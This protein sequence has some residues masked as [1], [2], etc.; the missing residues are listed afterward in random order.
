M[1]SKPTK[2]F[3]RTL[4][5][6]LVM[7]FVF[8][9]TLFMGR[10]FAVGE[11]T[12]PPDNLLQVQQNAST[13]TDNMDGVEQ[14]DKRNSFT[15]VYKLENGEYAAIVSGLPVHYIEDGVYK[16]IDNS[17]S[18]ITDKSGKQV[19]VN[20]D[21][22]FKAEISSLS[23]GF[24]MSRGIYKISWTVDGM[25]KDKSGLKEEALTKEQWNTMSKG[26]KRKN[27]PNISSSVTYKGVMSDVD[28]QYAVISNKL[29][30]NIILN[31][32]TDITQVVER[33]KTENLDL[34]KN[35]DNSISAV[36]IKTKE[37]VFILPAPF[38][39]DNEGNIC[40]NVGVDLSLKEKEYILTYTLDT[41]W[42]ETAVYPCAIDPSVTINGDT[43]NLIDNK[44]LS[45]TAYRNTCYSN[46]YFVSTGVGSSSGTNQ[47]LIKFVSLPYDS[48]CTVD[49]AVLRLQMTYNLATTS[50][51]IRTH[52]VNYNWTDSVTWTSFYANSTPYN[53]A[54]Y[55]QVTVGPTQYQSY[56][57]DIKDIA[58]SWKATNYGV[59]LDDY[60]TT[61]KYKIYASTNLDGVHP[62]TPPIGYF[63]WHDSTPP[64]APTEFQLWPMPWTN[65]NPTIVWSGITDNGGSGLAKAQYSID[66]APYNDIPTSNGISSGS[67]TIDMSGYPTGEYGINIRAVDGYG[68]PGVPYPY[69]STYYRDISAPHTPNQPTIN[70]SNDPNNSNNVVI[71][72]S[73]STV[74]DPPTEVAVTRYG[75][76]MSTD[77]LNYT[78]IDEKTTPSFQTSQPDNTE[79]YFEI[80]ACDDAGLY[81]E[82]NYVD[83]PHTS[84]ITYDRTGPVIP[85][86][87]VSISPDTS[88]QNAWTKVVT[89]TITWQNITD[90]GS[91]L[92]YIGMQIDGT[93]DQN[94]T[95]IG[96]SAN[97]SSII[98]CGSLPDGT[99]TVYVL[100]KDS[101]GN[102]SNIIS[103]T[104]KKD[105]TIN[106]DN[107]KIETPQMEDVVTVEPS[108]DVIIYAKANDEHLASWIIDYAFGTSPQ[109]SDFIDHNISNG[110]STLIN[111]PQN[112]WHVSSLNLEQDRI[113]TIKL[114]A[115]DAAGN[116]ASHSIKV[117]Y[118]VDVNGVEPA[119]A[120]T[121]KDD[122]NNVIVESDVIDVDNVNA[123]Y[124][125]STGRMGTLYV[126]DE[127]KD[128]ESTGNMDLDFNPLQYDSENNQW[129]YPEGSQVF[130]RTMTVDENDKYD[131]T[132]YS[133]EGHN[134]T[135]SFDSDSGIV[136]DPTTTTRI[137]GHIELK[138]SILEG[139]FTSTEQKINGRIS[140]VDLTVD[141]EKPAGSTIE[142]RLIYGSEPNN[143]IVL[144][145]G[146]TILD[147]P[148]NSYT[149]KATMSRPNTSVSPKVNAWHVKTM[150]VAF[151]DSVVV[152]NS[153]EDNGR[154][155]CCLDKVIHNEAHGWIELAPVAA[156]GIGYKTSG[157]VLS[158][159]RVTPGKVWE[160]HLKV[161][162]T[163][164]TGSIS[165]SISTDGGTYWQSIIPGTNPDIDTWTPI[166][167]TGN[168]IV[169]KAE[170]SGDGS[171]TPQLERWILKCRQTMAG[172]AHDVKF[173]DEPDNLSTLVDAN[174]MTLLRWEPSETIGVTY[175][176][177]RST[178]PYFDITT[179]TP[180]KPGVTTNY[181]S[182]F[183]LN[184][185]QRFYY[186]VTAV[187][188][189]EVSPGVFANRESL[190][191]NEAWADVVAQNELEKK[192]GLENY[193]TYDGYKAGNG[194]GYVNIA[195]GNTVFQSTDT[196]IPGPFFGMVMRRTYN[197][198]ADT[199]TPMGYGWDYSFNTCLFKELDA[200][201]V[202]LA[203]ILKDGD[204]SFHRFALEEGVYKAAKG[205]F[206]SL[207]LEN[208][209][210][211]VKRKDDV[212]YHFS[213]Q[214]MK[215][216]KF[217]NLNNVELSFFYDDRGNLSM[218][219]ND[220][221]ESLT[222]EYFVDGAVETD[223]DY[224]YVNN[225]VDMLKHVTWTQD[226][227]TNPVS[228]VYN[229]VYDDQDRLTEVHTTYKDHLG[230]HNVCMSSFD[231]NA[232]LD[233]DATTE[234][235]NV[236][237]TDA[238]NNKTVILYNVSG[239]VE[240][241][242]DPVTT[243]STLSSAH[244]KTYT[245]EDLTGDDKTTV[246]TDLGIS[247]IY[248]YD[249]N[250]VNQDSGMLTRFEDALGH[251]MAYNNDYVNMLVLSKMYQN[252]VGGVEKNIKYLYVYD[253]NGNIEQVKAQ[254]K[255]VSAQDYTD[256][257]PQTDYTYNTTFPNMIAT[258]SVKKD[259][260]TTVVTSYEYYADGKLHTVTV[261]S[262]TSDAK[263]TTYDYYS[264]SGSEGLQHQL[265]STTDEF[266]KKTLYIYNTKGQLVNTDEYIAQDIQ[267]IYVRT[268]GTY[269]YDAYGYT[270][271]LT[272][273]Y[274]K[275]AS[276]PTPHVTNLDYD[277]LGRLE[278]QVNPDNTAIKWEYDLNGNNTFIKYGRMNGAEFEQ[279]N[280]VVNVYDCLDR[281]E[282]STI[283]NGSGTADDVGS[284]INYNQKW[285]ST[286]AI[287]GS[288]SS[289][290]VKTDPNTLLQ[291]HEY[292]NI[293]GQLVKVQ[294]YDGSSY[295]T[296]AEYEYDAAG[297][298]I[299]S[300]DGAGRVSKAYYNELNQQVSTVT[301]PFVTGQTGHLNLET[302]YTY[303]YLG[304]KR[305]VT[306][307]SYSEVAGSGSQET[308]VDSY[309]SANATDA[310][311]IVPTTSLGQSFDSGSV[312]RQLSKA[313]FYIYRG[314]DANGSPNVYARLYAH[315]GTWGSTGIPATGLNSYLAQSDP[316]S[317]NSLSETAG[318]VEFTFST[319]YTLA[320]NTKYCLML[321]L[322]NDAS[323]EIVAMEDDSVYTHP[324]NA[325][326]D[327]EGDG[328]WEEQDWCD[329]IFEVYGIESTGTTQT[330]T[331][332]TTAYTYD[333]LS[334]LKTVSQQ[335]PN[336]NQTEK[337]QSDLEYLVTRYE[338]D[339]EG[340]GDYEGLICNST[341]DPLN[342]LQDT[343]FDEMGRKKYDINYGDV[344][345]N[346]GVPD[347]TNDPVKKTTIYDE[348]DANF[349]LIWITRIDGSREN[350]E[351]NAMGQVTHAYYYENGA[352]TYTAN[353]DYAYYD[354][355]GKLHSETITDGTGTHTTSYDYDAMGRVT[356]VWDGDEGSGGLDLEYEYELDGQLKLLNYMTT[357]AYDH[358]LVYVY[359]NFRRISEIRLDPVS[360][361]NNVVRK[362]NYNTTTG[363]IQNVETAR[364]FTAFNNGNEDDLKK[365]ITTAYEF[366][367]AGKTS[368]ITV[369]DA[370]FIDTNNSTGVTE[371]YTVKY[372]GRGYINQETLETDYSTSTGI[373][374]KYKGYLYDEIGR[375]AKAG[376]GNDVPA[377]WDQWA[378][379]SEYVYDGV[380]NRKVMTVGSETT[381]YDYSDYNQLTTVK[382]GSDV[383]LESY[384]FDARGNQVSV[385]KYDINGMLTMH[386]DYVFDLL[387]RMT[388]TTVDDSSLAYDVITKNFY[389]A[390][391]QRI[392]KEIWN[393]TQPNPAVKT[394]T[395]KYFYT[396]SSVL[397]TTDINSQIKTENVL[398][399]SG[400][401]I[402]SWRNRELGSQQA[403]FYNYDIRGSVTNIVTSAGMTENGYSYD[404]F[405]NTQESGNTNFLNETT[406]TGSIK[407]D[408][409]GL[410]YM[411]ARFYDAKSGRFLSQDSYSGNAYDPWTQHLYSYCGNNPTNFVDP[412]GHI[413]VIADDENGRPIVSQRQLDAYNARIA[414]KNSKPAPTPI[415]ITLYVNSFMDGTKIED[416]QKDA[417]KAAELLN[418]VENP[419]Y[420][421]SIN[422]KQG[423]LPNNLVQI[424]QSG[425][426]NIPIANGVWK[427]GPKNMNQMPE[428]S[429]ANP[430][431]RIFQYVRGD[432]MHINAV[433]LIEEMTHAVGM[434]EEHY[435]NEGQGYE[436]CNRNPCNFAG[437][438]FAD[439]PK[440]DT[441]VISR[442]INKTLGDAIMNYPNGYVPCP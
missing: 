260:G 231:Y 297:N 22:A 200:N 186:K 394:D 427:A 233:N 30:E 67:Y 305:S 276:P 314:S 257:G 29:I 173:I 83:S 275:N 337:P 290:I 93:N 249:D 192:L 407:D 109:E 378:N 33:L 81:I 129:I 429:L 325:I 60:Y 46:T 218:V 308:L 252:T 372:D 146:K 111:T 8:T 43:S 328:S 35:E 123:Y 10:A 354:T 371:R 12:P 217:T 364:N 136:L 288:E 213:A 151:S 312:S 40:N 282:S 50:S 271:T 235:H 95:Q 55:S 100:A 392:M 61:N 433:V 1:T 423:T 171:H 44:I 376:N 160:A 25:L 16:D 75:L 76:L 189:I 391:G 363:D 98:Q 150:Y 239:A 176:V 104:Y 258:Q 253:D 383:T 114:T 415:V 91:N 284:I 287:S 117:M 270:D 205:T 99:H 399:Q 338:Y 368:K 379:K 149:L 14:I 370:D 373:T 53:T 263:T 410:Q 82:D 357:G 66:G 417:D 362:Y 126:N 156:P 152:N 293:I 385:N 226:V 334:R 404:E 359:D 349:N 302:R 279:R 327:Y 360:G 162:Q 110:T 163:L 87:S 285:D 28:L 420:T 406:Y 339:V 401:I 355:N 94:W 135:D 326:A 118:A 115:T 262:G 175:N 88:S 180:I 430:G 438:A 155:F 20:K 19:Y 439:F 219:T 405:G 58:D 69:W 309:G 316:V 352:Q 191:S 63:T 27:V 409:T 220:V 259:S 382:N 442:T 167:P 130:I 403:Y 216:E 387:N 300:T 101:V 143:F 121:L 436:F 168:Q 342:R 274:N 254:S 397:Y 89:P 402:A 424:E 242:Y 106:P 13:I 347:R 102:S 132:N 166:T 301:D 17:M 214:T 340:E 228:T 137:D 434:D 47:T 298:Q 251:Y 97:G 188:S 62:G 303:D 11:T 432:D 141:E 182:D 247:S 174:Y 23:D 329:L 428:Q 119:L 348:Y 39:T 240:K 241:I 7:T 45:A 286:S 172:E 367:G 169:L 232:N 343:Y 154:G 193:W 229:Y 86:G 18:L 183:N 310:E 90:E 346:A 103:L 267:D 283:Q 400:S 230:N 234:D 419:E 107:V 311:W 245:Y 227:E 299:K 199:K 319:P 356:S 425:Q 225:N 264:T 59:L 437:T 388:S 315:S 202:E 41:K 85:A 224:I 147:L 341:I 15:K 31:K 295:L 317:V 77:N 145:P 80:R 426:V 197:L 21:N 96:S 248:Y 144:T 78:K 396:G 422:V 203:I 3:F 278:K 273:A 185:G 161:D 386:G 374:T 369:S 381:K 42:L 256:L 153:F 331:D 2:T 84:C 215:L 9:G 65:D 243:L 344:T 345:W 291:T 211:L 26:E 389:N 125:P 73:C 198:M 277:S 212:T 266:G 190:A 48:Y 351:Y 332:Y 365:V 440:T 435:K 414:K 324:G 321:Y 237:I 350:Y 70:M 56:D 201:N 255:A 52:Y 431:E 421:Y 79:F 307:R 148:M 375:L 208:N 336:Y 306:Q 335:N 105:T 269:T 207:T 36:D 246:T 210:Y 112:L 139:S 296:I 408:S 116:V 265:K 128:T 377:S 322:E 398:S 54:V 157:S 187:K 68:N 178:T 57:F 72:I 194:T 441:S 49:S 418:G 261:A 164:N 304:N 140:Y 64:T 6:V 380:G 395:T 142:Y 281:L 38:I 320:A 122:N 289:K 37:I 165:Y 133:Y 92:S 120:L 177:Y 330:Y 159:V 5:V 236:V 393:E 333:N 181:W 158:T 179:A 124:S 131:Y 361:D 390:S 366:N 74:K 32:K 4:C 195:N 323:A 34:I 113:Y 268:V 51:I 223:P 272:D 184:Y 353:I 384:G 71:G 313:K 134:I 411:N 204:G 138:A 280:V 222:F 108:G 318:F 250:A 24:S 292:Y 209:E 244:Y 170:L 196:V 221:E 412:T 294:Q 238:N 413:A 358:N 206:M 416:T 127:V